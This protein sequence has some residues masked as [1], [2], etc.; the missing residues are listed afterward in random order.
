[1]IRWSCR[2][3]PRGSAAAI[4]FC[5]LDIGAAGRGIARGVVV[6][7]DQC[8]G[9]QFQGPLNHF[10]G[11]D[12]GVVNGAALLHLVRDQAVFA[13]QEHD[14]EGFRLVVPHGGAAVVQQ[15]LPG[16]DDGLFHQLLP[17]Q[18]QGD[19]LGGFQGRDRGFA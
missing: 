12:G 1:M 9:A 15:G 6:H 14:A 16:T 4:F 7:Q 5:H 19:G 18:M 11:I 17:R 3:M 2:T 10:A 13:V 8:R